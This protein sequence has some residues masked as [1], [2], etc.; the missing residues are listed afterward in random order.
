MSLTA[1]AIERFYRWPGIRSCSGEVHSSS[2][3]AELKALLEVPVRIEVAGVA[4][5]KRLL[6]QFGDRRACA[7]GLV[8][9]VMEFTFAAHV[10]PNWGLGWNT[11]LSR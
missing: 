9:H 11:A 2:K 7:L 1:T 8:H 5:P 3:N 10:V 6:V 4:A